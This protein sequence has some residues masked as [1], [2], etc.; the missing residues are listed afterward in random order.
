MDGLITW[1]RGDKT[2][3]QRPGV[4]LGGETHPV[5]EIPSSTATAETQQ[6]EASCEAMKHYTQCWACAGVH[7]ACNKPGGFGQ[8]YLQ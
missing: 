1:Y 8:Q 7:R 6:V 4:S 2:N 3:W 5:P